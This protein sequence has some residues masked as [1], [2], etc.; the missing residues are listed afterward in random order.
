MQE[1]ESM[2]PGCTCRCGYM[3]KPRFFERPSVCPKCKSPNWNKLKNGTHVK[4]EEVVEKVESKSEVKQD[5][6][7]IEEKPSVKAEVPV[8]SKSLGAAANVIFDPLEI[9]KT[10]ELLRMD[11]LKRVYS[12]KKEYECRA[13]G[14][15][16]EVDSWGILHC[17]TC[18]AKCPMS[19][20]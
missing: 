10:G 1:W 20:Y 16:C 19:E 6:I 7:I 5:K 15:E 2:I 13:C 9:K 12:K 3:W 18:G 17:L 8:S 14:G 4:K 11:I